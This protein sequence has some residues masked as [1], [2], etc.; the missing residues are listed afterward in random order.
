MTFQNSGG[1]EVGRN[2]GGGVVQKNEFQIG[3][4]DSLQF[5]YAIYL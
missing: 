2:D 1:G 5:Q 3:L 4:Y